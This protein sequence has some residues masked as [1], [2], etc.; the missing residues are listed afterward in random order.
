MMTIEYLLTGIGNM[1][2]Y[3]K[4]I[5]DKLYFYSPEPDSSNI[6]VINTSEIRELI[7]DIDKRK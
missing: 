7:D 4:E 6:A 5:N 3:V 2:Y 1:K